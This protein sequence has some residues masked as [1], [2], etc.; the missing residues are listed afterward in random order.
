VVKATRRIEQRAIAAGR[1]NSPVFESD[2]LR[3]PAG[4]PWILETDDPRAPKRPAIDGANFAHVHQ[5]AIDAV[6]AQQ[7][8]HAI[9]NIALGNAIKCD[10]HVG[11]SVV[12]TVRLDDHRPMPHALQRRRDRRM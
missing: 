1:G 3:H 8:H 9:G 10:C 7:V 4:R 2:P 11:P 12:D 6:P 5:R